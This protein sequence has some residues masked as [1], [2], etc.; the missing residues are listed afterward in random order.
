[1]TNVW[2]ILATIF[3]SSFHNHSHHCQS[4]GISKC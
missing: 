4:T 2:L 1:V 3:Y